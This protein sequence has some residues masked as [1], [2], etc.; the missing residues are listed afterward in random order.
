MAFIAAGRSQRHCSC[1]LAIGMPLCQKSSRSW[2]H[3]IF[4]SL[5][6]LDAG[7]AIRAE[8]ALGS[9]FLLQPGPS[10]A[11][12]ASLKNIPEN[13]VGQ[14]NSVTL[15]SAGPSMHPPS[16]TGSPSPF[17][18]ADSGPQQW[19]NS[20]RTIRGNPNTQLESKLTGS[21]NGAWDGCDSHARQRFSV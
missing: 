16:V 14:R 6:S 18:S 1:I 7:D 21:E 9:D 3:D 8:K 20:C 19:S 2:L 15:S 12:H 11:Y 13:F 17:I 10:T 4:L 5:Q